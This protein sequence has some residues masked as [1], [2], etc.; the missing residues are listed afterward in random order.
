MILKIHINNFKLIE[1]T[2]ID[3]S[4][5][6]NVVTGETG[7]GK[8]IFVKGILSAFGLN[9]ARDFF[10]E[11]KGSF[12]EVILKEP[13]EAEGFVVLRRELSDEG[14]VLSFIDGR[15][16]KSDLLKEIS[17]ERL[18]V[19]SQNST[20]TLLNPHRQ[21]EFLDNY[22]RELRSLTEVYDKKRREL[23][24][25]YERYLSALKSLEDTKSEIKNIEEFIEETERYGVCQVDE[26]ELR[27]RGEYLKNFASISESIAA[28]LEL[29]LYGEGSSA[30][31]AG[32]A[33]DELTRISAKGINLEEQL[34]KLRAA[35]SVLNEVCIDLSSRF[36]LEEINLDELDQIERLLFEIQRIKNKYGIPQSEKISEVYKEKKTTLEKLR[37]SIDDPGSLEVEIRIKYAELVD[38]A[39]EIS[40][41]RSSVAGKIEELVNQILKELKI[42]ENRFKIEVLKREVGNDEAFPLI[43]VPTGL[44]RISFLFSSDKNQFKPISKIAS[45]GELSR[46]MLA[47][48]TLQKEYDELPKTYVFD[49]IDSGIGGKTAVVVGRYLKA[50]SKKAQI[51]CITHLP[52][53]AVFADRHFVI[54]KRGDAKAVVREIKTDDERIDEIAR[55][56]SGDLSYE[57][58]REHAKKLLKEALS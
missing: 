5:G 17:L 19:H 12:I 9:S 58:A 26:D 54:E 33:Y 49:E 18:V 25:L 46:L 14:K 39:E 8:T 7:T 21:L 57:A 56:L 36:S 50:L 53:I 42:G 48:E 15:L 3:F 52:Q 28:V 45:G 40:R 13:A 16:T 20:I 37:S 24:A 55:M 29:L 4:E 6:L 1:N 10:E 41:K 32:R 43:S 47:L 38:L 31:K 27:E 35:E 34:E 23:S 2:E 44:D 22:D 30:E 11:K 51:I